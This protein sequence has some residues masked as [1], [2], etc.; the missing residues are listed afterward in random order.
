MIVSMYW[1]MKELVGSNTFALLSLMKNTIDEL[2]TM[3]TPGG[4]GECGHMKVMLLDH[5]IQFIRELF[6]ADTKAP[7]LVHERGC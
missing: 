6:L 3:H 7:C 1:D 2:G 5:M 4:L